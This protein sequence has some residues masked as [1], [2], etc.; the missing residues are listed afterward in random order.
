MVNST[1][2]KDGTSC[3]GAN[4][5]PA[6]ATIAGALAVAKSRG[7][8]SVALRCAA[9][10]YS[11]D[12]AP[13][14]IPPGMD[15]EI[16]LPAP[17][18]GQHRSFLSC[19][20]GLKLPC[21]IAGDMGVLALNYMSVQ[22]MMAAAAPGGKLISRSCKFFGGGTAQLALLTGPPSTQHGQAA[23]PFINISDADTGSNPAVN[24]PVALLPE[25]AA[26][27]AARIFVGLGNFTRPAP[28]MPLNGSMDVFK[29]YPPEL[30]GKDCWQPQ[31]RTRTPPT[32]KKKLTVAADGSGDFTTIQAAV[33]AIPE[34]GRS[35]WA[36]GVTV[37]VKAG[38]YREVVCLNLHKR[39]VTLRGAGARSTTISA[40]QGS[41]EL[42]WP[43]G[44]T[45]AN[46]DGN[47]PSCGVL[48]VVSDDFRLEDI[49]VHN[50]GTAG[51]NHNVA[52]QV[53]GERVSAVRTRLLGGGDAVGFLN[54]RQ[55]NPYDPARGQYL[56][57]LT[58]P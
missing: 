23:L 10:H 36:D 51:G 4:A 42:M 30:M 35:S 13:L 50:T 8:R 17:P 40:A 5:A 1:G 45:V 52:L 49:G 39:F 26:A 37:Y 56:F 33:N 6:C 31:Y 12:S 9:G 20:Q 47:W 21:L 19:G 28:R 38:V 44:T 32:T 29:G 48:R 41:V 27:V 46:R 11:V 53:L 57:R 7:L 58:V 2:G 3:G 14:T 43:N 55:H 25:V 24:E 22:A 16:T 18:Y 54:V 34:S 15:I